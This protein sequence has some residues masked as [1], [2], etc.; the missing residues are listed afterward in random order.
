VSA[1]VRR[2]PW[3]WIHQ[4]PHRL[5]LDSETDYI[6]DGIASFRSAMGTTIP[7]QLHPRQD[8]ERSLEGA[9]GIGGLLAARTAIRVATS[10]RTLSTM[11]MATQHH[12]HARQWRVNGRPLPLDPFG[13]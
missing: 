10:P 5:P 11:P 3:I 6:Y 4:L 1:P 2:S 12:L 13:N 9:G 7:G 8:A